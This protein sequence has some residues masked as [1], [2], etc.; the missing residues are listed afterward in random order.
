M[1]IFTLFLILFI[2]CFSL[3]YNASAASEIEISELVQ[4][5]GAVNFSDRTEAEK[6]LLKI[7]KP[8]RT[9]LERAVESSDPEIRMRARKILKDIK[10]GINPE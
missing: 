7:G 5:L 1:S 2:S 9:A 10:L 4:K 8:A 3:S 6:A